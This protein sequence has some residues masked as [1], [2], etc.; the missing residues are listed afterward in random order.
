M[1]QRMQKTLK[2][3]LKYAF[4]YSVG[5]GIYVAIEIIWRG[6]SHW[7]MFCL[8]GTCF[9]VAGLLNEIE[10]WETPLWR[11]IL[12]ALG[13][14]LTGEFLCG[15]VVNL[16]LGWDV[17]DYSNVPFNLMGQICL[18]YALLWIPLILVAII[19]DD[20]LRYWFF[21]EE[22]PRYKLI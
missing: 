18:P 3:L 6:F 1:S 17:W 9:I 11:Q 16:W 8:A 5:G 10:S 13:F 2:L 14:T 4:L 22:K 15:C 21:G 7:T 12:Q 19:L 20:Y